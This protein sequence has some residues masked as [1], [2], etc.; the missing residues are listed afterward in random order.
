L[1]GYK[2]P[3]QLEVIRMQELRAEKERRLNGETGG[4]KRDTA[5]SKPG[6]HSN[7]KRQGQFKEFYNDGVYEFSEIAGCH[8]WSCSMNPNPEFKGSGYKVKNPHAWNFA[9]P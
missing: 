1:Q 5:I 3:T 6:N 9:S 8:V 2:T 7:S 4:K